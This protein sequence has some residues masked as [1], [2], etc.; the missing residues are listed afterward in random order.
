MKKL[1]KFSALLS[2]V[3]LCSCTP[4]E[5]P[6]ASV[7]AFQVFY[8]EQDSTYYWYGENKEFTKRGSNVWTWGVRAYASKDFVQWEDKGLII[9]P[10][11]TD[12]HSP[13]HYSQWNDRPHIIYNK[14]N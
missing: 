3:L 12:V 11:T 10:D 8:N 13:L 9:P 1:F 2:S 14:N 7:E 6:L 5:A 4:K